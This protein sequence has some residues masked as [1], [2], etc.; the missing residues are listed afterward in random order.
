[1]ERTGVAGA[2]HA[3]LRIPVAQHGDVP[4]FAP[5]PLVERLVV[6]HH[7]HD[8]DRPRPL[9]QGGGDH[10]RQLPEALL[11]VARDDDADVWSHA[12]PP[13]RAG[14]GPGPPGRG[15]SWA[16][17]PPPRS[18]GGTPGWPPR[19]SAAR[20]TSSPPGWPGRGDVRV[21]RGR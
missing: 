20:S 17:G 7:D 6:V 3:A 16:A 1:V 13:A 19:T 11:A 10:G 15:R 12:G 2:G 8:L 18:S 4:Q 5:G 14:P 21:P 9:G